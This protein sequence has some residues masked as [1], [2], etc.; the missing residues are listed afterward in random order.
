M[1]N[2]SAALIAPA[3]VNRTVVRRPNAELRTR[4]HLTV[5]EV[6]NITFSA[7][8]GTKR[9]SVIATGKPTSP[10]LS[11]GPKHV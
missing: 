3:I 1:D 11:D 8:L 5:G 10:A 7:R 9:T 6:E 4:E 2:S